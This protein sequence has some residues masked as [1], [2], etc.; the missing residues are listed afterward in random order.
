MVLIKN[1]VNETQQTADATGDTGDSVTDATIYGYVSAPYI[2]TG[3]ARAATASRIQLATTASS[4]D[5][6]YDPARIF[7]TSGTGAGQSRRILQ[8]DG[9]NRYAY[10]NRDWKTNPDNTSVYAIIEDPGNGH[11]NEGVA[12]GGGASTITLNTL[13]SASNSAYLGQMVYI[14]AGTG[15]DQSRTIV[16]YVGA[17][18]VATVDSAWI[19]QPDATSNYIILP[20]TGWLHAAP[21]ADSADNTLMRDV[22]GNKNDTV[23]GDSVVALLKGVGQS[24][25]DTCQFTGTVR[26]VSKSGDDGNTGLTPDD[27]FLTIAT[28]IAASAAGDA[29]RVGPGA[30]NEAGLDVDETAPELWLEAGVIIQDSTDGVPLTV[31][32]AFAVVKASGN[33]RIDPTGGANGVDVTG[34]FAWI[35]GLRVNCNSV[36]GNGFNVTANGVTLVNPRCSNPTA[37]NA[38]IKIDGANSVKV[39]NVCVGGNTASYGVWITGSADNAR[40]CGFG[41]AGNAAGWARIDAGCTRVILNDVTSGAGDGGLVDNTLTD[42]V[43]VNKNKNEIDEYQQIYPSSAGEG[44]AGDPITISNSTTDGAGGT[45]DDQNYWGD[46]AVVLPVETVTGRWY[47]LGIEVDAVTVNDVQ[48]WEMLFVYPFSASQNGGNDWDENETQ[49]TVDDATPFTDGDYIWVVGNDR[50]NGEIVKVS[51][52]PAANVV[53][54]ARETTADGE[55]GLRYDYDTDASANKIYLLRKPDNAKFERMEGSF[56]AASARDFFRYM[57]IEPRNLPANTGVLMRMLNATD[58]GA[59]SFEVR[60]IYRV[61]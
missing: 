35:E 45:R 10:V 58:D 41:S 34:A 11:V 48:Q 57:W 26:Y 17:T 53:T 42:A 15:Q 60:I 5:G 13:A 56:T 4:T 16:G 28:A 22:I 38:A 61:V 36:G 40:I 30:Y 2:H 1:G 6:A 24:R 55:A 20:S 27:A 3:T 19:T 54:I 32:G 23:A 39:D 50:A 43:L 12:Q 9:T 52:A 8:Y 47:S 44:A 18:K 51:G 7:I 21:S 25:Y 14:V 59:S 46:C 49:L 31:S 29:I 37:G 33:V